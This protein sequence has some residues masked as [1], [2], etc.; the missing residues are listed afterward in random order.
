MPRRS[1]LALAALSV[2]LIPLLVL[3]REPLGAQKAI[4]R[5]PLAIASGVGGSPDYSARR[6]TGDVARPVCLPG[7]PQC[8][9]PDVSFVP[10]SGTFSTAL[11]SLTVD[12]CGHAPLVSS[13]R[14]ILFN[15]V[16]VTGT[17]TYTT[18]AKTGCSS[19]A[20]STGT[21]TLVAGSNTLSGY[22]EDNISQAG[23]N[24]AS[25]TL[26]APAEGVTVSFGPHNGTNRNVSLCVASCFDE[27]VSYSTPSYRS[28]DQDRTLTVLYRSS[29][30]APIGTVTLDVRDTAAGKTASKISIA[31]LNPSGALVTQR[32][33]LQETTFWNQSGQTLRIAAQFDAAALVT[34]S[35][36]YTAILKSYYTDGTTRTTSRAVRVLV[37]NE[38]SSP[39]GVG[40]SVAG[41]QRLYVDA[42]GQGVTIADGTGSAQFFAGTCASAP[43]TYAAP[44]G[45]FTTVSKT[46]GG[47]NRRYPNGTQV[48]FDASGYALSTADRFGN[49]TSYAYSGGRLTS[50]TDPVGQ[51]ITVGSGPQFMAYYITDPSGRVSRVTLDPVMIVTDIM[52]PA[53]GHP[54]GGNTSATLLS[55]W[56][57]RRG[58]IWNATYDC[59]GHLAT[60]LAPTI[61][62]NG[63]AARPQNLGSH[64]DRQTT[65]CTQSFPANAVLATNATSS[66]TDARGYTTIYL[67]DAYLAPTRITDALGRITTMTRDGASNVTDMLSPS[68]H[69][70]ANTWNGSLLT[71]SVDNTTQ[72]A[73][74]Y[75][76]D[77]RYN[78]LTT[79]GGHTAGVQHYLN[80]TGTAV[81]ST[82]IAGAA[83]VT[84]YL[85]DSKGRETQRTDPQGHVTRTIYAT[86]QWNNAAQFLLPGDRI[87]TL[88]FDGAGRTRKVA[89]AA[90]DTST[91]SY[92]PLNRPIQTVGARG[93]V[94]SFA[95]DS[96]YLKTV[97]DAKGQVQRYDRNALG[98]LEAETDPTSSVSLLTYDANGNVTSKTNRRGQVIGLSYDAVGRRTQL[99]T[100]AQ[101]TTIYNYDVADR[102]MAASNAASIDTIQFDVAGRRTAEIAWRGGHRLVTTSTYNDT[103]GVRASI[104]WA[105]VPN[106]F[107]RWEYNSAFEL[108]S[109]F[110]NGAYTNLAYDSN[111]LPSSIT[112]PSGVK[113][114]I[115][116]SSVGQAEVSS[117]SSAIDSAFRRTVHR[118]SLTRISERYAYPLASNADTT[119]A[120]S[121][122]EAGQLTGY[123]DQLFGSRV[124]YWDADKN[125]VCGPSSVN[126]V[127]AEIYDYDLVG[128]RTDGAGTIDPGNRTRVFQGF[129]LAY[130]ADGNLIRKAKSGVAD[131]S[132]V[133]NALGE[134]TA[135]L[136][137]GITIAQITYDGFGRRVAKAVNAGT[138]NYQWD[139]DHV[140]A[141]LDGSWSLGAEYA[142]YPGTDKLHSVTISGSSY[143]AVTDALE[144]TRFGR[145]LV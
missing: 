40:W 51:A 104:A 44:A 117:T 135:V 85:H 139:S 100:D 32:N 15:G 92:D 61:T 84:K 23:S 89:D 46:S 118:D 47:W 55:Q 120:F 66:V 38:R 71:R 64:V 9:P 58:G 33:G 59:S 91:T 88:A 116:Y 99:S 90:G 20:T 6:L 83:S 134:L 79:I 109:L 141:E 138:T 56:T 26:S 63:A 127:Q 13:A 29:Q 132:L 86:D 48:T 28:L 17:F 54:F 82:R 62:A 67:T 125:R 140:V 68:G 113:D 36:V 102:W 95:Y 43:C 8:P 126:T 145:H 93:D 50:V 2:V 121:F 1:R 60:T 124:C 14:Q 35:Y 94:T 73:I 19:H 78:L 11:Q 70:I 39:Y 97:T 107:V 18:S 96:L 105:A 41:L 10:A 77:S 106:H 101:R 110:T 52:D 111:R 53:G 21:V 131:D 5:P 81:D 123:S 114:T 69:S 128:N 122:N 103:M 45:D 4:G 37:V 42:A 87:T 129:S 130:D 34:G 7:N 12:W 3:P 76:Y 112:Y 137:G 133:W 49:T 108:A 143:I 75:S 72:R 31:L 98:W 57:D 30:A 74:N 144:F 80:A 25:Y 24:G 142:F 119:R 16:D 65:G 115:V 27:V 22:I 136:R